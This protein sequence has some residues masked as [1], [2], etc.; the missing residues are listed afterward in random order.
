MQALASTRV[1]GGPLGKCSLMIGS[2]YF[3]K[4]DHRNIR[5]WDGLSD[6]GLIDVIFVEPVQQRLFGGG[7]YGIKMGGLPWTIM[8]RVPVL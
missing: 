1:L 7:R 8:K 5:R 2:G 4:K 3:G 6:G